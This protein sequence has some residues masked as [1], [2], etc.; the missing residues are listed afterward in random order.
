MREPEYFGVVVV[1]VKSGRPGPDAPTD[2]PIGTR[3][4]MLSYREGDRNGRELARAHAYILPNGE[5]G[6]SGTPDPK[7][8]VEGDTI[9][10]L[11][12]DLD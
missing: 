3:S 10:I 12:R 11:D 9:Y 6:A 4:V 5:Y 2:M 7:R 1:E 8:L